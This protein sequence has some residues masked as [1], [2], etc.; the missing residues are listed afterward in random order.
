MSK[1]LVI[2]LDI[3]G[4]EETVM[5]QI[6]KRSSSDSFFFTLHGQVVKTD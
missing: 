1:R 2:Q 3:E 4:E 6:E 5:I